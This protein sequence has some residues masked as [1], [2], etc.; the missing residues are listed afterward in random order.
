MANGSKEGGP[1]FMVRWHE[2]EAKLSRKRHAS[3]MVGVPA[4]REGRGKTR[5]E[6]AVD[7][8]RR[9]MADRVARYQAH[10]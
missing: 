10:D 6:A 5:G 8:S 1:V 9:E 3:V 4:N 2:K 7:E